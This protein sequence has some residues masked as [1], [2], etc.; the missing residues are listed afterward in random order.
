MVFCLNLILLCL[1]R[2]DIVFFIFLYQ[3]YIYKEDPT[4]VNEYGFSAEMVAEKDTKTPAEIA[5]APENAPKQLTQEGGEEEK[6]A[7]KAGAGG[8]AKSKKSKKD[9]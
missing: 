9:D 5:G 1:S 8:K 6:G 2:D 4:R 7:A 3:R